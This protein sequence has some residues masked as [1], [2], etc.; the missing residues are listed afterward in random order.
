MGTRLDHTLDRLGGVTPGRVRL[1]PPPGTATTDDPRAA[2][3]RG[4]QLCELVDGTLVEKPMGM[5]ESVIAGIVIR[6]MG[7]FVYPRRLGVVTAPDGTFTLAEMAVD[8]P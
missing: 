4:D 8:Q 7:N 1:S 2:N 3:A 6:L 5:W